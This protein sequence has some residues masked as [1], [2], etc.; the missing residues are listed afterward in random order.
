M[1]EALE[2]SKKDYDEGNLIVALE[3]SKKEAEEELKRKVYENINNIF[4][5]DLSNLHKVTDLQTSL[6]QKLS[7]LDKKLDIANT[8]TPTQLHTAFKKGQF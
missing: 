8:S 6:Y 2:E 1:V 7:D 3:A 5:S 4:G